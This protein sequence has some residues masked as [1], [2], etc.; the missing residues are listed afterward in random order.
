MMRAK[1]SIGLA[2]LC[3]ACAA[4]AAPAFAEFESQAKG[5]DKGVG[6]VLQIKIHEGTNSIICEAEEEDTSKLA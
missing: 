3:G 4:F 6:E 1:I 5:S 2:I